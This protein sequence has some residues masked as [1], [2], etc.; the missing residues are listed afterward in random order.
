MSTF[1]NTD[2]QNVAISSHESQLTE[3]AP[4]PSDEQ[5]SVTK[6]FMSYLRNKLIGEMLIKFYQC[7]FDRF[8]LF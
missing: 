8:L 2:V 1:Y 6:T 5:Q 4:H 3:F 7:C